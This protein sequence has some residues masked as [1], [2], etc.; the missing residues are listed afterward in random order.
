MINHA[1]NNNESL[2]WAYDDLYNKKTDEYFNNLSLQ[3][4][5]MLIISSVLAA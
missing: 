3:L 5:Q 4:F 2:E 1:F